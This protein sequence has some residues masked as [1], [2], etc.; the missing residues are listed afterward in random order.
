MGFLQLGKLEFEWD[1]VKAVANLSKHGVSFTEAA[2]AFLDAH[3]EMIADVDHSEDEDRFILLALSARM[4]ILTVIH[5]ARG[6][7]IRLIS[8]RNATANERRRYDATRE[9]KR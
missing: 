4:R 6:L 2:T 3:A 7:R 5:V 8:A 1:D 9:G